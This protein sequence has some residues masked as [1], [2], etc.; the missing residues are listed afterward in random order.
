MRSASLICFLILSLSLC[1]WPLAASVRA[2][3]V[4]KDAKKPATQPTTQP[5]KPFN[6]FCAVEQDQEIDPKITYFWN[7]K[8]Y[9]FCCKDCIADFKKNPQK[10]KNAK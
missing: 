4:S 10:Y 6:K 7:G 8:T 1:H 9:G 3:D 5:A 2:A